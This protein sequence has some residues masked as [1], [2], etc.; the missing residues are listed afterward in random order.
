MPYI[1]DMEELTTWSTTFLTP[2]DWI[3]VLALTGMTRIDNDDE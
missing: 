2:S 3:A 1:E